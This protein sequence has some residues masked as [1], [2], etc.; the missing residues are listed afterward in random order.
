[1]C[2]G[3]C[4]LCLLCERLER[5]NLGLPF[6]F[7][8][9]GA[10]SHKAA[11]DDDNQEVND[12][13]D[14]DEETDSDRTELDIIKTPILNSSSTEYYEE[15]EEKID[16]EKTMDDEEDDEVTKELYK[17]V[18]VNLGN[19]DIEMTNADQGGSEQQ[20]ICQESGFEQVEEDAHKLL[21]LENPSPTDNE[22]AS[23]METS[24]RQATKVPEITSGLTTTI[25]PP[26]PFFNP[27]PQQATPTPT[28]SEATTSFPLLLDFS[29]LFKFN[30]R[31]TNL[32]KDLSEIKQVD[33]YTQALSSIPAIVD[34]SAAG[35]KVNVAT[36]NYRRITTARR[37]STI[38]R[39]KTREGIK[40]KIVYQDYLRDKTPWCIKG[41]PITT[42]EKA[43]KKNDVKARTMLLMTLP[44]EHLMKFNQ[45]KDAKTL[46]AAIQKRFG[47]NDA[48]KKTQK[49]LLKQM[50]DNFSAPSTKSLDSIF[51]RLQNIVSQLA[52]LGENISQ[53]DLNLKFLRS[54]PSE[55]NTHVV[56]WRNK[57]DLETMSFDDLYN[58]FKIV[59]QE[60][61][62][63]TSLSSS[64]SS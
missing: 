15:K 57:P 38:R 30:D 46:F 34:L 14:D 19:E 29:S 16:D 23:L 61:K 49:T 27:L 8:L 55:W 63:T 50:Y 25:P 20:N 48:T 18:N 13:N 56:V 60:V 40:M 9:L 41:G 5:F 7:V 28:T 22:I 39:I 4:F 26:P 12:M 31:V 33:Q 44:N 1:M 53:E 6:H 32:E 64:S 45:Y 43:Q 10:Q 47:G 35:I 37:V 42:E 2:T 21:N 51:N 3:V 62:G 52:I 58:N 36:Y 11:N 59:E 54:L 17:D 24:T